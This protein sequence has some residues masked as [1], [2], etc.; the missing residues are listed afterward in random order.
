M[1]TDTATTRTAGAAFPQGT[2][3]TDL[4]REMHRPTWLKRHLL[5]IGTADAVLLPIKLK[6]RLD[7]ARAIAHRPGFAVDHQI[8][9]PLTHERV[10][11]IGPVNVQFPQLCL[12][13]DEVCLDR[14]GHGGLWRIGGRDADRTH[15]STVQIVQH[16]PF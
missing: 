16:M 1:N 8:S 3:S 2:G 9:R 12:L 13:S 4:C 10:T 14:L 5:L 11:S 6:G 7:K 15:S